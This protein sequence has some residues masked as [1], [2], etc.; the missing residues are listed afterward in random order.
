M[1]KSEHKLSVPAMTFAEHKSRACMVWLSLFFCG[2]QQLHA[3]MTSYGVDA[4]AGFRLR[5]ISG[6]QR[7]MRCKTRRD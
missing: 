6:S 3:G 5:V 4:V 1:R 7:D 2:I